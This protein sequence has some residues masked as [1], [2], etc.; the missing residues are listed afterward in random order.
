[1][2]NK[3]N[4]GIK[5]LSKQTKTPK[6]ATEGSA[7]M[8]LC[9]ALDNSVELKPGQKILVPTGIAVQIPSNFVGLI[10]GRSGLGINQGITLS[11]SVG[12]IDSDYRGEIKC[13]LINLGNQKH[14]INPGDRIA[15]M[16]FMPVYAGHLIEMNN[17]S[18]TERGEGGFGSTGK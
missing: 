9:A 13:G 11:N 18:M 5:Y 10:F 8:D 1:M 14:I 17:L 15:Q 16:I 2:D 3:I 12:V 7:G 6:Y 4:V